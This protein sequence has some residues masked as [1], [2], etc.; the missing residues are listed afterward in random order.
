MLLVILSNQVV[1]TSHLIPR[2]LQVRRKLRAPLLV[3]LLGLGAFSSREGNAQSS[4]GVIGEGQVKEL[5][6]KREIQFSAGAIEV[7]ETFVIGN[8][9]RQDA[10]A[11]Y[12]FDLPGQAALTSLEI[13]DANGN[14]SVQAV[15]G[16]LAATQSLDDASYAPDVGLLRMVASEGDGDHD[17]KRYELR[18]FPVPAQ[19]SSRVILRWTT[20]VRF[21]SGSYSVRLAGRGNADGVA[22]SEV[23]LTTNLALEA[24]YGGDK[25]L[26]NKAA[27]GQRF[28]FYAPISSDLVIQ[29][30][31]SL[32]SQA[33]A[34][35]ALLPLSPSTGFA[36]LR[37]VVPEG[38]ENPTPA[39][40]RALVLIDISKSL[41]SEGVTAASTLVDGLLG[42]LGS[43]TQVEAILFDRNAKR[44][45]GSF[46]PGAR[47]QRGQISRAIQSSK[48]GNG[49]DLSAALVLAKQVFEEQG[50]G[51]H[52]R[53][54]VVIVSDG[55][56]PTTLSGDEASDALGVGEA[57]PKVLSAVL[58]PDNA[59]LPDLNE[60]ALS[61]LAF[62]SQG[63]VI[64]M[65]YQDVAGRAGGL[66]GQLGQPAPLQNLEVTLDRGDW[67]GADLGGLVAAGNSVSGF[68]YYQ[69]GVPGSVRITGKREGTLVNLPVRKL[70]GPAALRLA[71]ATLAATEPDSFPGANAAESLTAMRDAA[72][73]FGIVTQVSALV[74]VDSRD[75]FAK[76]R[77]AMAK[78]WG[79]QFYRRMPPPAEHAM[80]PVSWK[81]FSRQSSRIRKER[82]ATG[83]LDADM[84]AS[85]VKAHVIP[86]ARGCYQRHLRRDPSAAGEIEM[87]IE[88]ARGEVQHAAITEASL[89][90][91]PIRECVLDAIYA[92]PVPRVRLGDD[93]ELV[94]VAHYPLRFRM[95]GAGNAKVTTPVPSDEPSRERPGELDPNDP[96]SGLPE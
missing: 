16:A 89:G 80:S 8:L 1:L 93:L 26:A 53:S 43:G 90:L 96:L 6:H 66:L 79:G 35:V 18:V 44:V 82:G 83:S 73:K 47:E 60:S 77:L 50:S 68:G 13:T 31:P 56:L 30:R 7:V 46:Q 87:R 85:R 9:G 81:R 19:K 48:G 40:E 72:V 59:P 62:R 21:V 88:V 36:A 70:G 57:L 61:T 49:S 23:T 92:M 91:Q 41:D 12:E 11:L 27:R 25:L 24:L 86:L 17:R 52:E 42:E 74:A 15:V 14:G 28:S 20:P 95:K 10:E 63:R 3:L 32:G 34:E 64:A 94:S 69:G 4:I 29:G 71:Q 2:Y 58:V 55:M 45:L 51:R 67:V 5:S 22:R 33:F 39:I 84:I 78:R 65:R 38:A 75:G 76:D 37:V 54:L